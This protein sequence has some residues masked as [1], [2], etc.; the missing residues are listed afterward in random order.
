[1]IGNGVAAIGDAFIS[2]D[3][4]ALIVVVADSVRRHLVEIDHGF[5]V[6]P[7][8]TGVERRS[9]MPL[10]RSCSTVRFHSCTD[11]CL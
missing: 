5:K 4:R 3:C 8:V 1:M 10:P 7:M 2:T 11:G 6:G 9:P